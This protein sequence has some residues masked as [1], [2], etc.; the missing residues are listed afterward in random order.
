MIAVRM[1]VTIAAIGV[2]IN[3][4]PNPSAPWIKPDK[5]IASVEPND[6]RDGQRFNGGHQYSVSVN[7]RITRIVP[8]DTG[9]D[10]GF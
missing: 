8:Q 6:N 4:K 10:S 3:G 7:R 9:I 2:A 1:S 5:I